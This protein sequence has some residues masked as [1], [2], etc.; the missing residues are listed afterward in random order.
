MK[1]NGYTVI[2]FDSRYSLGKG[3][4]DVQK[5]SLSTFEEDLKT[6]LN[7][8]KHENF[9][10][11]LFALVGHPLGGASILEY[12]Q[13]HLNE[14][15]TL[16]LITPIVGGDLWEKTCLSKLSEFCRRWKE[17]GTYEYT[18]PQNYKKGIVPSLLAEE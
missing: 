4:N 6:V 1:K 15:D 7:L 2:T 12:V 5:A 8:A 16:V 13:N 14:V 9:Y 17:N 3:N 11:D 10:R 18:D